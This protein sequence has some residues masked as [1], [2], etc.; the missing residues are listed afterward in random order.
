MGSSDK[1][2]SGK[3]GAM[4]MF[5]AFE[6]WS[7]YMLAVM[8]IMV[9]LLFMEHGT[10]KL[11]GFP[12]SPHPG[13]ALFSLLGIQGVIEMIGGLLLVIGVWARP[14]AFILSGDMAVAYFMAHFPHSFFPALNGGDAAVLYCLV[15]LYL[16]CAGA[17]PWSV[18]NALQSGDRA[19][20]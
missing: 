10:L 17:G 12:P 18:D 6:K 11:F 15:F 7:P 19:V 1:V 13:P 4:T 9:A 3:A 5:S 8:R 2:T 16:C 14:V 20:H